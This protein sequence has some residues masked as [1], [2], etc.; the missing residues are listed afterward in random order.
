MERNED[1]GTN[2]CGCSKHSSMSPNDELQN[3]AQG[4]VS[5]APLYVTKYGNGA[6]GSPCFNSVTSF[7]SKNEI[8]AWPLPS[9]MVC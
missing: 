6:G 5:P 8:L 2:N 3:K 1:G 9:V 4:I 7:A